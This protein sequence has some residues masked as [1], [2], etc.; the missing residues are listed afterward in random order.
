MRR[1][2]RWRA[3]RLLSYTALAA[4][5]ALIAVSVLMF[6][7]GIWGAYTANANALIGLELLFLFSVFS[8]MLSKYRNPHAVAK[9][10]GLS[11]KAISLRALALAAVLFLAI[12]GLEFGLAAFS[13]ATKIPLPT[14]VA[15]AF[16]GLPAYFIAFTVFVSPVCEETLFRGF[17]VPRIGILASALVFA[18]VHLGYASIAEFVGAFVFGL[19]AGYVFKRNK[20]LYATIVAHGAVNALGIVALIMH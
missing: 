4:S 2:V 9:A 14:N 10:L 5:A 6:L 3:M 1:T 7:F 16:A 20:S 8:Y 11:K 18:A 15:E 12:V 13:A 19:A 17:M